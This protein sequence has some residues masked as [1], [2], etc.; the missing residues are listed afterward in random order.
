M[1]YFCILYHRFRKIQLFFPVQVRLQ[2]KAPDYGNP[3]L[4]L[5]HFHHPDIVH[6]IIRLGQNN[7]RNHSHILLLKAAFR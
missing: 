2:Q 1:T 3:G 7:V 5:L 6:G 4:I